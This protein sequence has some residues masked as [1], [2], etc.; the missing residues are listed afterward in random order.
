M[1]GEENED[2]KNASERTVPARGEHRRE[3]HRNQ[4]AR[5]EN[6]RS[7][8]FC[9]RTTAACGKDGSEARDDR[10][11]ASEAAMK[12]LKLWHKAAGIG[13]VAAFVFYL[14]TKPIM[15]HFNY[16]HR[17]ALA[18]LDGRLGVAEHP[19]WLNELIPIDGSRYYTG[20]Y[21]L[22]AV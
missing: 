15:A 18:L 4:K 8:T 7:T 17:L 6:R 20:N 12:R 2:A 10:A 16:T 14:T 3:G 22:G 21:C 19:S 1:G 13:P 11:G 5:Q 9:G